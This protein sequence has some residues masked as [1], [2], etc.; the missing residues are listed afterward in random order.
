[1]ERRKSILLGMIPLAGAAVLI[2]ALAL[3]QDGGSSAPSKLMSSRSPS[4]HE[5]AVLPWGPD[6]PSVAAAPA[7]RP[8]VA[9]EKTVAAR[10]EDV[11]IRSTY[12]NYRTA[13]ATRNV[14]LEQA[15]LPVVLRDRA[16]SLA[17]AQE[18]LAN[19]KTDF[20][21]DVA[22]KVLERLRR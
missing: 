18:D 14:S 8:Q 1:M 9:S 10:S 7:P 16:S 21:R 11:R 4:R 13:V 20:D 22:Q 17:L 2:A 3:R 12:Q 15:I 5:P 6:K 19:A